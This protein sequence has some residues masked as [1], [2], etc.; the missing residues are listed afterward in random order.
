MAKKEDLEAIVEQLLQSAVFDP[1]ATKNIP[2]SQFNQNTDVKEWMVQHVS[3]LYLQP[4]QPQVIPSLLDPQ[5]SED[6]DNIE[7]TEENGA[8][9]SDNA[10]DSEDSDNTL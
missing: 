9:E 5:A 4:S 2:E 8:M 3:V 7:A 1:S 10:E 6:E